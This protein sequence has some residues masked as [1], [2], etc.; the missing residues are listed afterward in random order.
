MPHT[1]RVSDKSDQDQQNQRRGLEHWQWVTAYLV[2]Y[3]ALAV[4]FSFFFALLLRF[5]LRIS[6][7][8]QIYLE[9][10]LRFTPIYAILSVAVF[11]VLKLYKSIWRFASFR[12]LQRVTMATVVTGV[13]HIVGITLLYKR[14]PVS[15]YIIGIVVQFVMIVS[16][17]FAYRFVLLLRNSRH[18]QDANNA[19]IVGA[20]AAG[21]LLLRELRRAPEVADEVRCFVDDNQ[22]KWGRTIDNVEVVGGR[23]EIPGP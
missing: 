7:I 1:K 4:T 13:L 9:A 18:K 5:D 21:T 8:P 19:M 11:W 15:Y 20:G 16:I 10:F 23:Y 12:E 6:L 22:N 14:M 3:D 17:R 2:V